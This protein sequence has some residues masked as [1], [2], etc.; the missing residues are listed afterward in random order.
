MSVYPKLTLAFSIATGACLSA[1]AQEQPDA[2][3]PLIQV[4][5]LLDTSSSMSGLIDQAKAQLWSFVNELVTAKRDGAPPEFRVALYHYGNNRLSQESN[6]IERLLPL[7]DDLDAVSEKLFALTINGGQEYCGAVI[8]HAVTHLE[9]SDRGDDLKIILIAGNEPFNQGGVD[10]RDACRQAASKGII[11]NTVFCGPHETGVDTSWREGALLADGSYMSIDHNQ[12]VAHISAPQDDELAR[13]SQEINTTYVA[14][15]PLGSANSAN[16]AAQDSN[17]ASIHA[18]VIAKR[19]A[20]KASHL[21]MNSKWDLVDAVKEDQNALAE[22][23]QE[24][25]PEE[26]R[27]MTVEEQLRFIK[28]KQD[29]RAGMQKQILEL[30]QARNAFIAEEMKKL[31]GEDK[32]LGAAM[33]KTVRDQAA[34]KQFTFE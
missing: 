28:Q 8:E 23:K 4:A 7:T 27:G 34:A 10:F 21:Y 1:L 13:L 3:P 2:T 18:D 12:T 20:V 33:Q 25:L 29:E 32:T 30:H 26:L 19:A 11:V 6:W 17:A 31:G 14:Y 5:I 22:I 16:Q 24:D 9:W 15:G